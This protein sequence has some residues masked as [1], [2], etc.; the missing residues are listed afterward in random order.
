MPS[1]PPSFKPR[2]FDIAVV[3]AGLTGKACALGLAQLGLSVAHLAPVQNPQFAPPFPLSEKRP[4]TGQEAA[5][6]Q[7]LAA[8]G[9]SKNALCIHVFGSKSTRYMDWLNTALES[10]GQDDGKVIK[11]RRAG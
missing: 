7:Q 3:G 11:L 1:L 2:Q 8:G 4:L 9:M 5:A 6:V 10:S